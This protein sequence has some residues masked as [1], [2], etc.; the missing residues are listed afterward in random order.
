MACSNFFRACHFFVFS[1]SL[2]LM[3]LYCLMLKY[4]LLVFYSLLKTK[5]N[6]QESI[7]LVLR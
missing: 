6:Q 7:L 3:W 2:S 1:A 5:Q 4:L